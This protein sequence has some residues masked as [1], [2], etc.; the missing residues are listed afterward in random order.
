[1]EKEVITGI[2]SIADFLGIS[3]TNCANLLNSK[4][5]PARK[6]GGSRGRWLASRALLIQWIEQGQ[7]AV[8]DAEQKRGPGRPRKMPGARAQGGDS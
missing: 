4:E 7:D 8:Q 6:V 5:I 3:R 1:M 2:D